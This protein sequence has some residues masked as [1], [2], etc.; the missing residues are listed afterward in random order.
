MSGVGADASD[1]GGAA[2]APLTAAEE[3]RAALSNV[4][5]ILRAAGSAPA[6]IVQVTMLLTDRRDYGECNH[7]YVDWF[8]AK[9][10]SYRRGKGGSG[11]CPRRQRSRSAW[12]PVTHPSVPRQSI[13][14][15]RLISCRCESLPSPL[16]L[17]LRLHSALIRV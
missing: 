6:R 8:A 13:G 16:F 10:W 11:K 14:A 17:L 2:H 7:A 9:A 1:V 3:T 15:N 5:T 4:A 12:S